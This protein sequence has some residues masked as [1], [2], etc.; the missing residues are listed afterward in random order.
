MKLDKELRKK[1]QSILG[2]KYE[3]T[4]YNEYDILDIV[5]DLIE[6]VEDLEEEIEDIEEDMSENYKYIGGEL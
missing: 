4:E 3:N 5:D 2:W 1:L 6:K